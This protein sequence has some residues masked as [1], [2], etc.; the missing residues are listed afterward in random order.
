MNV[1]V[2]CHGNMNR[3]P[4]A[5]AV[6]REEGMTVRSAGFKISS[7]RASKKLRDWA[8]GQFDVENHVPVEVT[9]ALVAWA[10]TVLLMDGGNVSRFTERFPKHLGKVVM[11]GSVVG[12]NRIPDPGFIAKD[13]CPPIFELVVRAAREFARRSAK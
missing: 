4:L 6:L 11:L 1:L 8:E 5:E 7:K 2:L 9:P 12:L 10:D 13:R 3:S